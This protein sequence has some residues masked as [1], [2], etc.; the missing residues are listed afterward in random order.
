MKIE[1]PG[2]VHNH[3]QYSNLRLRDCIIR[4][5]KL[6]DYA[7]ELGH[8]VL[9]ITDHEALSCHIKAQKYYRKI[10]EKHPDFKLILGNEIYLC[11]DGLTK[12]NFI[13][14]QDRYYHF[15][16]LAK[17]EIGH[18]QLR[19]LSTRAW[20]RSWISKGKMRRVP[21]YYLDLFEVI[22]A[23]PGHLIGSTACLGGCLPTQIMRAS[24]NPGNKELLE[25]ID[26]WAIQLH[27]LFGKDNFYLEL[28]PSAITEQTYVNRKLIEMS[29]RLGIPYIITTDSHYLKKEDAPIHEAFLNAQDGDR[30]VKSFYLTTYMMD[31][32]EL[33][34]HLDLTEEELEKAYG[35]ILTIRDSCKDYDLTK[36]LEIPILPWREFSP[37]N[38]L[39][40][41]MRAAIPH[42]KTFEESDFIG[43]KKLIDCI[44]EK[45]ESDE[46]LQNKET[47]DAIED[48]LEKT[49]TSSIKNKTHWSSY[50]LNLQKI[51]DCCWDAGTLVGPGR[52][53]GVGFILLYLCDITQINPLWETVQTKSWRFL[54]PDRV[55]V[56]D[57]DID[58]EGSRRKKVLQYLRQAYGEDYVTNV[59]T[60]GTEK[61][62]SAIL[63]A[64]RGLGIDI[65]A[66]SAIA[67]LIPVDR[68]QPRSLRQCFYGDEEAGFAPVKQFVY[69][70]TEN[71]PELWEVALRIEGL[72]NR[73]GQHAGGVI[74]TDKPLVDYTALMRAPDGTL[75]TAYDLHDDEAVSLIKY[76]L[77]SIEGLDKI[78]NELDLLV[79]YGY[80]TPEPTLKETYEKV[81]GIYNLERDNPDMWKMI[82]EHRIL[83]LFQME[84][85]SGIQGIALTHPQSV[86]DLAHLNSVIRLMAQEKGA[87]LPLAKYARFKNDINLWYDEMDHYSVK[88]EHQELLKKILLNSYGICEAQELFME[89]VQIPECGGFDL[90]WADRLRKS[91]AKK[92]ASEFEAL[93]KEYYTVTKE[94][95]LDE[96]LCNYVW[97]VLVSTS[98]GYGFNLSHTLS[99]S[100]VALQEM[101]LAFKYPLI[102]WDCAC[103]INDAGGGSDSEEESEDSDSCEN[104]YE[105]VVVSSIDSFVDEPDDDD[106]DD[107]DDED[108]EEAPKKVEKKKKKAKSSNY[109]K[110]ATAIGKMR[111]EGVSIVPPDINESKLTFSPNV[112]NSE[113]RYGLT[114]ITRVGADIVS[115]IIKNRPYQNLEDLLNRVKMKKPQVIN[116]IK[117]G[118]LDCFGDRTEIMHEYIDLISGKKKRITLQNMRMLIDF[119]LIPDEYDMSRRVFNYNAYLRKLLDDDKKTYLL[120]DVAF[121]FY[122]KN[123]DMDKLKEDS[124]AESGF[125]ILKTSWKPIYDSY[126]A[127]VR[128]YVQSHN[129]ELLK[130]VNDRLES[131]MW[132]KYCKGSLSKWEMDSV[133]FYSHPHELAGADLSAYN[134]VDY[135]SLPEEPVIETEI[136][137]K[138]KKIPLYKIVR[139]A[140]TVLDRDKNK[141][142]VTLLTTSGVVTVK[143]FGTVF[144]H[145]DKQISERGDD[146]KKHV[147]E[148]SWFA[149]GSKIIV[150]G[151][152]RGEVF[153]GKKYARTPWHLV[154]KIE[155]VDEDGHVVVRHERAGDEEI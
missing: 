120:N 75:V 29:E 139:I 101:N 41:T 155:S 131:D 96:H 4:E 14:G 149:R 22:G 65:D 19:E 37:K 71:Y 126:M 145:Y 45:V 137:I 93:E 89:L 115:E 85:Q 109:G 116:L 61:P 147:I 69:E 6:I 133:S 35:N 79:E 140:G 3:T 43:D 119:G 124:R 132:N 13:S 106:E 141:H 40:P 11:R 117:A 68:G 88:K 86:D 59:A 130:A 70:M 144:A 128:P 8:S 2:S 98:R 112:E 78:H 42:F 24:T 36:P 125:S 16:L 151:I 54:N 154:E 135:F 60:F 26:N 107:E 27:N 138:G 10:K 15:I 52:G 63:T 123:F 30:E 50:Y 67:A 34:S 111:E 152:R 39:R 73:L 114:G 17:D 53:S 113:I 87:E 21:T 58:I 99:Y 12:D 83:S 118:A 104:C 62:K 84:Q 23:N 7:I 142:S 9:A 108:E 91:I 5:D 150:S 102:L 80:V 77:L 136:M 82:W 1:Y 148:K 127:K 92:K 33:E 103:L 64:A 56:L 20:K 153:L 72:V 44:V 32:E 143:I 28:Q 47:Y 51:I 94:K 129:Q 100:L 38:V 95:G 18:A 121:G 122:E 105:E 90:N 57:V 31:T 110:V 97:S 76:D 25:R 74:F 46:R 146:G 55:S 48:C 66:A 81:V 134:C 49:W